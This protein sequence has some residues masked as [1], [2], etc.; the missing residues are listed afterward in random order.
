MSDDVVVHDLLPEAASSSG[1]SRTSRWL[2][3]IAVAGLLAAGGFAIAYLLPEANSPEEAVRGLVTAI[4]DEDLLG[5]LDAVAPSERDLIKGTI[6]DVADELRRLEVLDEDADLSGVQGVDIEV[7]DLELSADALG[8]GVSLV[9]IS[10]DATY[11]V[12]PAKLPIGSFVEAQTDGAPLGEPVSERQRIDRLQLVAVEEGGRWYVSLLY[13]VA[14]ALRRETDSPPPAFGKGVQPAGAAS[15]EEAVRG[16]VD[17]GGSLDVRR[18]LAFL[19]PDE[20]KAL[21]DYAPLFLDEVD[22][23]VAEIRGSFTFALKTFDTSVERDGD[24]ATVTIERVA[25]EAS[26]EDEDVSVAY[27][28]KCVT[29]SSDNEDEQRTCGR[30]G[31]I[32]PSLLFGL[33]GFGGPDGEDEGAESGSA[34]GVD[35]GIVTV[36]RNGEW[37]VS[38]LRTILRPLVEGLRGLEREDLDKFV[39]DF[40]GL[41]GSKS[42]ELSAEGTAELGGGR[43]G[44]ERS[45]LRNALTA[46]KV[47]FTE[48]GEWTDD[49]M[50]LAQIEPGMAITPYLGFLVPGQIAFEI[51]GDTLRL[52]G[53]GAEG[54][55]YLAEDQFGV[56]YATDEACGPPSAQAYSPEPWR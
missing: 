20:A 55:S 38:P 28:G 56:T 31:G 8:D 52:G 44:D 7:D 46:F 29:F 16:M 19:P 42:L 34:E 32:G 54:C 43:S 23:R 33:G 17:A 15:P 18:A 51:D 25:V 10:A 27:D 1:P 12:D 45:D 30:A 36:Q 21:H 9:S 48:T 3:G 11:S 40:G 22:E 24:E 4:A 35:F 2:A 6:V 53:R 13:S 37:Y 47:A 49:P 14:D 5:A 26:Y 50:V 41:T 39:E